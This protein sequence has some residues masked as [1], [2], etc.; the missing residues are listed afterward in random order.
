MSSGGGGS[1]P[2]TK[3][4]QVTQ[5]QGKD[6]TIIQDYLSPEFLNRLANV[7]DVEKARALESRALSQQTTNRI[8][9]MYGKAPLY[10]PLMERKQDTGENVVITPNLDIGYSATHLIPKDESFFKSPNEVNYRNQYEEQKRT[11]ENLAQQVKE[12]TEKVNKPVFLPYSRNQPGLFTRS[13]TPFYGY[14]A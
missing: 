12:L 2:T 1:A 6:P 5:I 8:L 4:T 13:G 14:G 9:G 11:N 7:A 10:D 3:Q